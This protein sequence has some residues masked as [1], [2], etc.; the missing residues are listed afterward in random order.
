MSAPALPAGLAEIAPNYDVLLCDV[1]GVIHN[2]RRSFP[3]AC[4]AL[5][6]FGREAGPVILISN[7]ARPAEA[8][9]PQLTELQV[10]RDV[11][12]DFVTSGDATR[13]LL[14]ERAPGPV[15]F[16]GPERAEVLFAGLNMTLAGTQDAAFIACTGPVDDQVETPEDYRAA[17]SVAAARG[18]D[19]VCANPDKVVRFGDRLIYCGGA[20][21]DLYAELGGKV[22]MAGKPYAPIYELALAAAEK[23]LGRSVD[24]SRVLCVGDGVPT[25]VKGASDQGLDCLFIAAGIHSADLIRDG[26]LDG[27]ATE[28]F[29]ASQGTHARWAMG[30]LV[31]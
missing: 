16:I 23:A 15:W 22:F 17:L 7:A 31:W 28:A 21:A 20:L 2:G 6:R 1:W 10:P 25:D 27:P 9:K 5:A 4:A 26:A 8:V 29:L 19:M 24:R 12:T 13:D 11:W 18:I 14:K 30:D 3:D